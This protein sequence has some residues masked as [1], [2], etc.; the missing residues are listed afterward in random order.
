VSR[1]LRPDHHITGHFGDDSFQAIACTG[2]D[3]TKQTKE[4]TLK[5][6]KNTK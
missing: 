6:P 3:N 1:V 2:T 4:N 5:T